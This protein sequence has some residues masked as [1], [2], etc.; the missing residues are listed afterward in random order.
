MVIVPIHQASSSAPP[1][2]TPIIDLTLPKS[3][4]PPTQE[5]VFTA[6]TTTTV[7]TTT[8]T[9]LLP[10][11]PPPQQSTTDPAL[12]TRVSTL[13]QIC[14]NFKKKHKLQDKTTQAL[15]SRVF[16]L[17]NHDLYLK[18][19]TYVNETVRNYCKQT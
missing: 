13:E 10:P 14:A 19:D 2:S 8:T 18:I 9:T 6:T 17:E 11:P 1:L 16:T 12:A 7:T 3:V 4:S 15:S 5:P